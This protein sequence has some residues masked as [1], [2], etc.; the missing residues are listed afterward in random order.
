L[1]ARQRQVIGTCKK[2]PSV[3]LSFFVCTDNYLSS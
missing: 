1:R 3:V 2:V